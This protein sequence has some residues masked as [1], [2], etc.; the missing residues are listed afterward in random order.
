MEV[1]NHEN[2][3]AK[4][5]H[6]LISA[7]KIIDNSATDVAII[8]F[9]SYSNSDMY[10]DVLKGIPDDIIVI[11]PSADEIVVNSRIKAAAFIVIFFDVYDKDLLYVE[12]ETF[13]HSNYWN[14]MAKFIF[15]PDNLSTLDRSQKVHVLRYCYK[16]GIL[17]VLLL[18]EELKTTNVTAFSYSPFKKP[19]SFGL[20]WYYKLTTRLSTVYPDKLRNLS[21]YTYNVLAF[22]QIPRLI[23]VSQHFVGVDV[24]FINA[25]AKKQRAKF[26]YSFQ[27]T[28]TDN[29]DNILE[30]Y[31]EAIVARKFD[32]SLNTIIS[33]NMVTNIE[34]VNTFDENGYCALIPKPPRTNF[35][36]HLLTPFDA[37]T[38]I[39]LVMSIGISAVLWAL[40]NCMSLGNE[41]SAGYFIIGVTASF[42]GHYMRFRRARIIQVIM[43]EIFIFTTFILGSAYQS[44]IISLMTASRNGT[45]YNSFN[46]I[47]NSTDL[48]FMVDSMFHSKFTTSDEYLKLSHRIK[49]SY[50]NLNTLDYE[51]LALNHT[52]LVMLCDIAEYLLYAKKYRKQFQADALEHYYLLPDR[53]YSFFEKLVL[54]NDSPFTNEFQRYSTIFFESG[55]RQYWHSL[56]VSSMDDVRADIE[57]KRIEDEQYLLNM[58]DLYGV[59][60][61]LVL[62]LATAGLVLLLEIFWFDCVRHLRFSFVFSRRISE[63]QMRVNRIQVVPKIK[64]NE[65]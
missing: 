44:L 28:R 31:Y 65:Q 58:D 60:V 8:R 13:R 5:V 17:N 16:V 59:F 22:H 24:L 54:S 40:F 32:I 26:N 63:P 1:T 62:G 14:K 33:F 21:G 25:V 42:F 53:M 57:T 18:T 47:F 30:D 55:I 61:I 48:N 36:Q 39:F 41:N 2:H 50:Q 19:N 46:D 11:Q 51:E 49:V 27:L 29:K 56:K 35:L 38:W 6:T 15:I 23:K 3:I 52:A 45:K 4:Y 9:E 12:L 10:D 64:D 37:W 34:T 43:L 20:T 7:N